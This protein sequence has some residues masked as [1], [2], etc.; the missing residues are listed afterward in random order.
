MY[1]YSK[2]SNYI[3][4]STDVINLNTKMPKLLA[5]P[6]DADEQ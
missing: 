1:V 2:G 4:F 6:T 3:Y 5:S